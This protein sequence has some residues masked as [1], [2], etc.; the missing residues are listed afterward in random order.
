MSSS[1]PASRIGTSPRDS[2]STRSGRTSAQ[3]TWWPRCEKQAAVVRPTYPAPRTAIRLMLL[4]NS[5]G[6]KLLDQALQ[7]CVVVVEKWNAPETEGGV[8]EYRE[9]GAGRRAGRVEFGGRAWL[10]P[11]GIEAGELDH[12]ARQ[13]EPCSGALV[14][15]VEQAR[16][17]VD[18][19]PADHA[20][21]VVGERRAPV[22]VV[23]D[24]ERLVR[25]R[26]IDDR[27]HEVASREAADPGRADDRVLVAQLRLAAELRPP[28]HRERL[29][30]VPLDVRTRPS[31]VEDVVSRD[32]DDPG[33]HQAGPFH[34][35]AGAQ[36]IDPE[37]AVRLQLAPID[38]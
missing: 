35:V 2:R 33:A 16:S 15:D 27:L 22:L 5:C 25:R 12:F 36:G 29:G 17:A 11:I 26:P 14:R 8:V 6:E 18:G 31:P 23:D 10:H 7:W 21:E 9:G 24:A 4:G 28:V 3:M 30:G 20:G 1:R 37:G 13:P 34:D 32:V 38:V 19:E